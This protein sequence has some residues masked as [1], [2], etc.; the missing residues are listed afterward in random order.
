M[1][2]STA[3]FLGVGLLAAIGG[4]IASGWHQQRQSDSGAADALLSTPLPDLQ[5]RPQTLAQYRGKVLVVN[6]WATWCPPCRAEIPHFVET[7]RALG[8]KGVQFAGIALDNPQE[9]AAFAQEFAMKDR[10]SVV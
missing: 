6:F 7:Q 2:R 3:L 1:S 8:A 4:L 5:N 9:V 10:K